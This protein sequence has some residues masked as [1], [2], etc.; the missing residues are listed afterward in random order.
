MNLDPFVYRMIETYPKVHTDEY[1]NNVTPLIKGI[2]NPVF[3]DIGCGPGLLLRDLYQRFSPK[4]VIGVDLSRDMLKMAE[5]ILNEPLKAGKAQLILQHMQENPTLPGNVDAIFSSRVLRSFEDQF[6]IFKSMHRSL[7][8]GGFLIVL[9]WDRQSLWNYASW[10][11]RQEDFGDLH[12]QEVMRYHRNFSRYSIEDWAYIVSKTG[13]SMM[14]VF[15]IN[16]VH[17]GFVAM[18]S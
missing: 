15:R 1:W 5:E 9:D 7:K 11:S 14:K 3:L 2:E 4:K 6:T 17:I 8:S 10:M 18:K 13:F 16:E 12:P